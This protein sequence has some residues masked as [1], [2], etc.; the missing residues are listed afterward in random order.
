MLVSDI[1]GRFS[2]GPSLKYKT[3]QFN[4]EIDD[5]KM[6]NSSQSTEILKHLQI[7]PLLPVSKL[8]LDQNY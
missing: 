8:I 1:F 3:D 6:N 4:E 7:I 2:H 5:F